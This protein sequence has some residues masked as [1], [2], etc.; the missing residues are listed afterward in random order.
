MKKV[1]AFMVLMLL[2]TISI[3]AQ[4]KLISVSGRVMESDS[5]EPAA[6]ATVQLLSLP[7]STYAAGVA[8]SDK[9]WFTLPKVKAGKYLLKVSFIGFRTKF[10]PIQLTDNVS[11]KQVGNISLEPDAVMLKEAV[12]TAE[13]PPVI[14]KGDTTEYSAAAYPV[15]EGAMLEELVKKIPGAEVSDD[16]K[17]TINGK[18]IKKIMV[19]GKEFFSDDP[20][21]SMKNLPANIVDKVKSYDKKSDMAR[22]TGID[23]GN[24]ESVLDLTVKKG[25]KNG[26]IS[27]LIAGYGNKDRY[28]GGGMV[29]RF[30]DDSNISVIASANNTNNQGFSEFGDAGQ[31]LGGG[32]AGSGITTSQLLGVTYAKET[33]KMQVGGNVQYGH[34]NND[35]RRTSSSE[36]FL[37]EASSFGQSTNLSNRDRHDLRIDFRMEW[38]PDTLTTIIFRPNGSYSQ[39]ETSSSSWSRTDN[40]SHNPVNERESTSSSDGYNWS[41]NGSLMA[42]RRLNNKGRNLSLGARFG[43]SDSESDGYSDSQT[44]FFELDSISDIARYTDRN[45]DSRNWSVSASYT[46]PVFK[47]HFLQLRYEFAHRK[48]LSQSLV[49]DSINKYPYPEYLERG[50]DNDLSTRVENFYDTHTASLSIRGVY[51]KMFYDVGVGL[52]PQSSLSKTTI[53]PNYKKNLPEQNVL[54][55]SP[56]MMFRYMFTKQHVLMFRYNGRSSTPNIED[57]QDVIDITDPMNLRYGNPNLKPSFNSNFN[58]NYRRFIPEAMRSYTLD[59]SY[60]N[61]LNSVANKMTY[62]PQTGARIYK[63][64]NVNGNWRTQGFFNFNTPLKNQKFT[65]L[66]TSVVG[67]SDAVSYTSVGDVKKSEQELSTTHSLDLRERLVGRYRSEMFDV[68]LNGSVNYNLVRNS[69]QENSNRETFDY[70][71]GGST[72][73]NLPWQVAISTDVNCRFKNGYTGGL[74]NNEVMWNAQISKSFLKNNA[75]TLRFKIYDILKQQSSLTRSISETMMSDTEYNTLGSYF[76]VHFVYRFNTLGGKMANNRGGKRGYDGNR[77][78]GH[79]FGGGMRPM[80]Y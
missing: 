32:N 31:G 79:G 60:S 23:D 25:M 18:E 72:N 37:G 63:K 13:V 52:T 57:L 47:N 59:V 6:Q 46:E 71:V 64:E 53:G 19:D 27:N 35:A 3:F 49:Y 44:Q 10:L 40:N 33:T 15:P 69:K 30:K 68:S 36:T 55:W 28:E 75:A 9:G 70:Y 48:Q 76:M 73:V 56:S 29:S 51:A 42:F 22:I 1:S 54:N 7:D 50:Y 12:V 20:K 74:N 14:V 2:C 78:G 61:T 11:D 38:R 21:V 66:S 45:S 62:D 77:G 67:Y 16:G 26:I 17:I 8:S 39:T 24:E 4:N 65:I 5:E 80:R 43:Y 41:F 34:S 58:L